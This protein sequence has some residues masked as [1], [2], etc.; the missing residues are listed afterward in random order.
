MFRSIRAI[1]KLTGCLDRAEQLTDSPETQLRDLQE[2]V[3]RRLGETRRLR[4]YLE[5][6]SHPLMTASEH[7]FLG[8]LIETAGGENIGRGIPRD[9]AAINPEAVI[10]RNPEVIFIFRS[11]TT[12]ENLVRRLGWDRIRAVRS[13][14]I[15]TDL[16]EDK[17]FRPGPR[18]IQGAREIFDRLR[19]AKEHYEKRPR[20]R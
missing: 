9:Y 8:H 11:S 7:S 10:H 18:S 6:A 15:F 4:V 2:E 14:M 3:G 17:I 13:E 1:G 5:I 20:K 19:T 16:D 12:R